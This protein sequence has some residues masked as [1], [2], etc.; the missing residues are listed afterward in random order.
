MLRQYGIGATVLTYHYSTALQGKSQKNK[1][2]LLFAICRG[3]STLSLPSTKK[4]II[5]TFCKIVFCPIRT[6]NLSS[7]VAVF[8]HPYIDVSCNKRL[9]DNKNLE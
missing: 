1:T 4:R 8:K 7:V 3:G 6:L 5:Y 2:E 9:Q